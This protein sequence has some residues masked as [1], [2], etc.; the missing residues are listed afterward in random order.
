M[1]AFRS[2]ISRARRQEPAIDDFIWAFKDGRLVDCLNVA[3]DMLFNRM[4]P[5]ATGA[6]PETCRKLTMR[7]IDELEQTT[8]ESKER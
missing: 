7:M 1:K 6:P 3:R 2:R 8:N 5:G 4:Q